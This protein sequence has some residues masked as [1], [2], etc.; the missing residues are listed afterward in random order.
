MVVRGRDQAEPTVI[1]DELIRK[2][3]SIP[4]E[5]GSLMLKK[6]ATESTKDSKKESLEFHEIKALIFSF[7]NI[8]RVDNLSGLDHLRKLQLDNNII[9]KIENLSSL[10]NLTWLDLSFNNIEKI[11]GLETLVHLTDLSLFSNKI[12]VVEN[13]DTLTNLQV[14]SLGNNAIKE[15]ENTVKYLRKF[16]SLRCL[17]LAGNPIHK[18]PEYRNQ[19]LAYVKG[20]TYLDFRL[21]DEAAVQAAREALQS[22][23]QELEERE[24]DAEKETQVEEA[25]RQRAV[26]KIEI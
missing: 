22:E 7:K 25:R 11:D 15:M 12:S 21:V 1:D 17:N 14:L 18:D 3:I 19:V 13:L 2:C 23:L 5:E 24:A 20:L 4:D 16:K 6:D 9:E 8:L 26:Q 10:T